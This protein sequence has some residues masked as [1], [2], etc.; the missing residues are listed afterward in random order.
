MKALVYTRVSTQ[1]QKEGYSL[2]SQREACEK[3]AWEMGAS[4]IIFLEDTYSGIELERPALNRLREHVLKGDVDMVVI[5][6][7]DRLTRNLADLLLLTNELDR[8][9]VMLVFVNFTWE[10]TPLGRL[11]LEMRGAIAEFEHA[12][13]RERTLRGK[14][15]KAEEG[16]L[17]GFVEPYGY[18][19]DPI[20]DTLILIEQEAR[21]VRYIFLEYNK[22]LDSGES[23]AKKLSKMGVLAPQGRKW[24]AST[25]LRMLSNPTYLGLI[26]IGGIQIEVPR[27]IDKKEFDHAQEQKRKNQGNAMRKTKNVYLLQNKLYCALC[28][29]K[30]SVSNHLVKGK[31][32]SYYVCPKRREKECLQRPYSTIKLDILI[33]QEFMVRYEKNLPDF[34][35]Y[36]SSEQSQRLAQE[37]REKNQLLTKLQRR[38]KRLLE[39]LISGVIKEDSYREESFNVEMNIKNLLAEIDLLEKPQTRKQVRIATEIK[40]TDRKQAIDVFLKKAELSAKELKIYALI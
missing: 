20:N 2:E 11:F 12:L 19:F 7:P 4:E 24:H 39:L 25:V 31:S 33:W 28:G 15:K 30:M 3:K 40:I 5:Y 9:N 36:K 34:L 16:S 22:G 27:I 13:I 37:I 23:L 6:D 8:C 35:E 26:E 10:S 1:G 38:E 14:R 21:V 32:Y 29:S 18:K 17:P